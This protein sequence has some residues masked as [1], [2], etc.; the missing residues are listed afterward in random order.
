MT[1]Q[2][3]YT[4]K[5]HK[6]TN[7][8]IN[9]RIIEEKAGWK[10]IHIYGDS[11]ERGYAHGYLLS[12][13]LQSIKKVL[14]F[15]VKENF[16]ISLAEYLKKSKQIIY[17]IVKNQFPELFE[18]LRGISN[19][20]KSRGVIITTD[21][22]IAWNAFLSL[23]S[24]YKDGPIP[25]CSAFIACGDATEDGKIVMAHNTH[26]DFA[27]GQLLN[28]VLKITPTNGNEFTMQTSA[29]FIA[30]SSDWFLC[31][32][33]L[34]GCET[35]ISNINYE[36]RFGFPYFC[37]IRQ[38]MQYANTLDDCSRIM[39]DNNSGDY[40]CS[41][42]F[43]DINQNEIMLLELG[44][45]VNNIKKMKNGVF[46]GMNSAISY[47]LRNLETNDT[48]MNDVSLSSGSRNNRMDYLLNEKYYGK[49]NVMNSKLIISDHY[50]SYLNKDITSFRGICKHCE[51]DETYD[52]NLFGS[53]DSKVVDTTMANKMSF[54]GRFGSGC[55]RKFSIKKYIEEHPDKTKWLNIVNDIPF[56]RWVQI[57]T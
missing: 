8:Q 33:G 15:I 2:K 18:E 51:L 31:A 39:I 21:Y 57:K 3:K 55:G 20:A 12:N 37:R 41:W 54:A 43:G 50:D 6:K 25:H 36:P 1:N 44:L 32:N 28:I 34:I 24:Y 45:N 30:S 48:G 38:V 49:L 52:Y 11:F 56:Y 42:L 26:S 5:N 27:T 17:P 47:T 22:L 19:G 23:Y 29:G 13:E 9:G 46:Y 10:I 4:R 40:A 53:V 7:I 16:N 14:P 35:T